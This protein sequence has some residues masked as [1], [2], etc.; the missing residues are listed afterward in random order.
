MGRVRTVKWGPRNIDI[1]ILLFG[2][3]IVDDDQLKIP[4]PLM[5]LRKFVLEPLV[6]IEPEI[7]HPILKKSIL[8]MYNALE[9]RRKN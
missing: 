9:S 7:V 4:H 2:D 8:L 1:D 6:E 5:H 3:K